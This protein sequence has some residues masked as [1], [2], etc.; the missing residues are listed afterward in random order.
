MLKKTIKFFLLICLV[1]ILL[2]AF[3][4]KFSSANTQYECE[5][6]RTFAITGTVEP[7]KLFLKLEEYRFWVNL[8]SNSDAALHVEIPNVGFFYFHKLTKEGE[9]LKIYG[10]SGSEI[11]GHFSNLSKNLALNLGSTFFEGSCNKIEK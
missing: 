11:S 5:G 6:H 3:V 1:I 2:L 9:L 4:I 8:W 10:N 7:T